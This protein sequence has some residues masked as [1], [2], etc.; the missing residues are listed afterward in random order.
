MNLCAKSGY[1]KVLDIQELEKALDPRAL[2]VKLTRHFY[3]DE[4]RREHTRTVD[5]LVCVL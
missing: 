2:L 4:D 5:K 1:W 3:N